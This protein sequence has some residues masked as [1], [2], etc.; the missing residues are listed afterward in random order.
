MVIVIVQVMKLI[1]RAVIRAVGQG[2]V[3]ISKALTFLKIKIGSFL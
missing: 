2:T 3:V 1:G